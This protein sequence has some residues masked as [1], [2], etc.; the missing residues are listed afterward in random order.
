MALSRHIGRE[1]IKRLCRNRG[2]AP[3]G[4]PPAR[5]PDLRHLLVWPARGPIP[6]GQVEWRDYLRAWAIPRFGQSSAQTG[7]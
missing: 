3:P 6:V 2:P 5:P 4:H 7:S 1:E